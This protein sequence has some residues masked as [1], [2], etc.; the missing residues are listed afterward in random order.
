MQNKSPVPATFIIKNARNKKMTFKNAI[1]N[2][3]ESK[4]DSS[5]SVAGLIVGPSKTKKG[6]PVIFDAY[7]GMI[8][9]NATLSVKMTANCLCQ[10]TIEEYFEIMVKDSQS[11]FFQLFGEV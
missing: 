10:E 11:V 7:H 6:N 8:A 1:L 2:E 4:T 3:L 5:Q 9:P